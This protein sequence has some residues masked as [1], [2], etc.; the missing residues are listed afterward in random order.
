MWNGG[1]THQWDQWQCGF[2]LLSTITVDIPF[3]V[4]T[5]CLG[6]LQSTTRCNGFLCTTIQNSMWKRYQILIIPTEVC[7][8]CLWWPGIIG[9]CFIKPLFLVIVQLF[10]VNNNPIML[11]VMS[12]LLRTTKSTLYVIVK[13]ISLCKTGSDSES[14]LSCSISEITWRCCSAFNKGC[15][16][17]C[18]CPLC[19]QCTV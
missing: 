8:F 11:N 17:H 15:Y 14:T 12:T 6:T 16:R 5:L 10:G 19:R 18:K 9:Q 2:S 1:H 4:S 7:S 3:M 13:Q